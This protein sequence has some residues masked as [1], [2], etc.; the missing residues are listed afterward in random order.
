MI[1]YHVT[2]VTVRGRRFKQVHTDPFYALHINL[3]RGSVWEVQ[4]NGKRR[5]LKRV[6]N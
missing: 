1:T 5:L 3:W 6:W 4:P 2:G